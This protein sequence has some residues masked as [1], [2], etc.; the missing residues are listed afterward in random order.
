MVN[1]RVPTE[2]NRYGSHHSVIP[3]DDQ[4]TLLQP[5]INSPFL[6]FPEPKKFTGNSTDSNKVEN[7]IF[8]MDNLFVAQSNFLTESQKS[9]YAVGFLT[10]D[11]LAW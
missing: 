10:E 8:A 6:R 3:Q 4:E 9:A 1:V 5:A 2:Q 7:W 11:K